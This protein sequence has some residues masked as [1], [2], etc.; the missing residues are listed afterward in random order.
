[1]K[2]LILGLLM[3]AGILSAC[4][5]EPEKNASKEELPFLEVDLKIDPEQA[6]MGEEVIFTAHVTYD[7]KPVTDADE[8]EFEI[9]RSQS[10]THEKR[11]VSHKKDG[12]YELGKEFTEEGTYYVY[13]HVTAKDMHNMPKK[14][15]VI[16]KPSEPETDQESN[17]DMDMDNKEEGKEHSSH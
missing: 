10:E 3:T 9:W 12:I 13:A 15:F 6:E 2:K 8:V 11:E 4:A 14:E 5:N 7:G 17:M 16:G 1:M